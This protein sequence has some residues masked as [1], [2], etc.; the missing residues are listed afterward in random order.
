[1]I[2]ETLASLFR[3]AA[4]KVGI[5]ESVPIEI[6]DTKSAEHGDYSCNLAMIAAKA[7][8]RSPREVAS[9]L[10]AALQGLEDT[11]LE[12]TEVAGPGFLNLWIKT[13]ALGSWLGVQFQSSEGFPFL[14]PLTDT[15]R[16]NVEFVSV[17]PNG[18][19]T[20]GSG[21]GAA[22]G[23][24]LCSLLEAVGHTVHREYYINDGVNSEQMRLFG[25]SV[26]ALLR[27]EP[28]PE[29]GYKGDYVV[30][31]ADRLR[32]LAVADVK[33]ASQALM[34]DSQRTDL[35][36]FGVE[37]DTW[38]SE[39]SLH[40][41]GVVAQRLDELIA[42]Q[43][44][45]ERP[46]RT[47]IKFGKK[48]A[49]EE[50]TEEP[51]ETVSEDDAEGGGA[52]LWLRSTKFGDDQDRV[53]RRRDGRLTYIASDIAY[54]AD[55]LNRPPDAHQ[56]I[57][58]LGPDHHGYVARLQAVIAAL[59]QQESESDESAVDRARE[60]LSVVIFQLVRF[61]KDGKPAPMRKRDGNIYALIDLIREIGVAAIPHGERDEQLR[62]GRDVTRFF[63]L[64][65]SHDTS[66]DFDL[67]L[68]SRQSDENPV[69]YVQY[70]HAR[71]CSILEKAAG[72]NRPEPDFTRLSHDRERA[73]V[74]KVF[75]FNHEVHRAAADFGVHRLTTYAQELARSF[76]H[77]YDQCRVIDEEDLVMTSARLGLCEAVRDTLR[78]TLEL[79]GITAPVRMERAAPLLGA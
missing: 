62:I 68:A 6:T 48:G 22:F 33:L 39:Q 25:E 47:K 27:G 42:K 46:I 55:K 60:I 3:S 74:K 43:V 4:A 71:I 1:M 63:Y 30:A 14:Q 75:D 69:F 35:A 72:L 78:G 56:L 29:D 57:T 45:D 5:P 73:L 19:I 8:S 7:V 10:Q 18:P 77:F 51:Q 20:I 79:L 44:A 54:H 58:V 23:S 17:N 2:R 34:I 52:T 41:Q 36:A 53:L 59:I 37:F 49:I 9:E 24:A 11:V 50:I 67:D 65:R 12:R 28:V 21:R 76:H 26:A 40:D 31:V 64:M 66:M 13:S 70:A 15:R 61:V 16:I 38:F 32:G